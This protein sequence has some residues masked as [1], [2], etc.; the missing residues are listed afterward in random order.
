MVSKISNIFKKEHNDW[1][2]VTI[3]TIIAAVMVI[4][5][6][7]TVA[8][9]YAITELSDTLK[10][11]QDGTPAD[12]INL[13]RDELTGDETLNYQSFFATDESTGARY[14]VY[15]LE[16]EKGWKNNETITKSEEPLDAGYTYIIQNGYNG[17]INP[18]LTTN[19]ADYDEYLTKIAL[20]WYQ[21]RSNGIDDNTTGVLTANQKNVIKNS[22][23]N[24]Y[25]SSLVEGALKAK[26]TDEVIP[27]FN[28]V[29]DDK[30]SD[31]CNYQYFSYDKERH[32]FKSELYSIKS[33]ISFDNYQIAIDNNPNVKI[34]L[35]DGTEIK[36]GDTIDNNSKFYLEIYSLDV[37]TNARTISFSVN[38]NYTK[39]NVYKYVP[40][41][42]AMQESVV[43]VPVQTTLSQVAE[44][45]LGIPTRNLEINKTDIEGNPLSNAEFDVYNK[46]GGA[47]ITVTETEEGYILNN[48]IPGTYL[49]YETKTPDGYYHIIP[50]DLRG[51]RPFDGGG[52][53]SGPVAKVEIDDLSEVEIKF[54]QVAGCI[55]NPDNI[56][57]SDAMQALND[58]VNNNVVN[59]VNYNYKVKVRKVDSDTGEVVSGAVLNIV[60]SNNEVVDT[61]TTTNDYVEVDTSKMQEGNYKVVEVEAPNGYILS[62][63]AKTFTIDKDHTNITV[64]FENKKNEVIIDKKDEENNFVSG[65]VLR[66][67]RV[68]D[69]TTIDEWTTEDEG[70]SIKGL[71]KGEYKII[72]IEAPNGYTK[73]NSEVTF[74]VTGE[75]TE[76]KTVTFYNSDNQVIINKVDEEGNPLSGAKLRVTNSNGDLIEEFTT[77][78]EAHTL[79]K[80]SNGTYYVEEIEAPSGYQ[81]NTERKSFTV[82]ENTTSIQVTMVNVKTRM[83]LAKVDEYGECIPGATLRL[84]DSNKEEI[85]TFV[86]G[87]MPYFIDGLDYGTYYLEEVKAPDGYIK[88]N[89][90]V[91]INYTRDN[92]SG[93][94]SLVNR[95]GRLTI[96]KI[97]SETKEA[98]SG[99]T[100]EIR[101]GNEV[102][103]TITTTN[104]PTVINDIGEGTY[105]VVEEN[106]P[107]GYIKSNKEY[108]VTIDSN[109]PNAYVTIE[110]KPITVNLGKIDAKTGEYISGATMRL[111]REDGEMEP[112]TFVSSNS[113]Y[114]VKRLTPGVYSL[115]E[116]EAPSGY[117]GTGSKIT[118]R[119]LETGEVQ[120]VNITND[121]TTISINNR[122]LTVDTNKTSGYK[123][124]LETRDGTLIDEFTT[125][126]ENYVK[127]NLE[128]GEYI[129]KQ[130]EAPNGVIVNN[131]P[132]Y[133]SITDS[134]NVSII[135]FVNDFT[136]VN[137]SKKDIAGSAE[138]NGARLVIRNSNGEII[139]EWT[140]SN[141][142]YYIEKLPVGK[143][144]LEETIAPN[145]YVLNTS[146]VEFEVLETGDIQSTT[147][148]NSKLVEVPN[149]S[150]NTTYVY[151]VGGLLIIIGGILIYISYKNKNGIKS[152]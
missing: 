12:F 113:P 51:E 84:L 120:T 131:E 65:A 34:Y 49:I 87:E 109:N 7:K 124:Q 69:N 106:T 138:I 89:E 43:A 60:N 5:F 23:Y 133:F 83:Y 122:T 110:N 88:N 72:E 73:S 1:L 137:I 71:P 25:V 50:D 75:E 17:N 125:T 79:N 121:I 78:K 112:I 127:E 96:E 13:F 116:I 38:V 108:E 142:P 123:Y 16:K 56:D 117:V 76:A 115:E 126:K 111:N 134:N 52:L 74:E 135:N 86:S 145:G 45:S 47:P 24:F 63:K 139:K 48:L 150:S 19:N 31:G 118:F 42:E 11:G 91:K 132:I 141:N 77:T 28:I 95:R 70:Y 98:V 6:S 93:T 20:W 94:F 114:Q 68:S 30:N 2:K 14:V 143:Y 57:L 33:N 104:I 8:S 103:K 147:M 15:C 144:T 101:K 4:F 128:I 81:L 151:L 35:E 149:T 66:L 36:Q 9:S 140:S 80:L 148:Y 130:I 55:A 92:A 10:T 27:T 37:D 129:L 82:D 97:D 41:D 100:L 152:R 3:S 105:K 46:L 107:L 22:E 64:D 61:I 67:I 29:N 32:V 53:A 44:A 21:D 90:Q 62:D 40:S 58:A 102:V 26:E 39:Y 119:V 146:K 18:D 99:A 59:I 54:Q 136:K 85:E